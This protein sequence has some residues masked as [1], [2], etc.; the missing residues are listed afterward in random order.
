MHRDLYIVGGLLALLFLGVGL[1][2][3]PVQIWSPA[4]GIVV[5]ACLGGIRLRYFV[6]VSTDERRSRD[7]FTE[8][9]M[10]WNDMICVISAAEKNYWSSRRFGPWVR[11]FVSPVSRVRV[12]FK[13]FPA[14]CLRDVMQHVPPSAR[15]RE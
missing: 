12:N 11:E 13:L 3:R 10:K 8:E 9:S 4:I 1:I 5:L 7:L 15:T 2:S 14:E 6:R